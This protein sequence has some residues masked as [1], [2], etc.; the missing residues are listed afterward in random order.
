[1]KLFSFTINSTHTVENLCF[2]FFNPSLIFAGE[3]SSIPSR[4]GYHEGRLQW[5]MAHG[6]APNLAGKFKTGV[7]VTESDKRNT[8]LWDRINND[9]KK[10]VSVVKPFFHS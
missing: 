1:M 10:I 9:R 6:L 2:S 5:N 7:E 8:L 3:A 4:V